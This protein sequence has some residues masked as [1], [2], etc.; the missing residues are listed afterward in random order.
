[1]ATSTYDLLDSTTLASAAS[2][3]SF[4]SIDQSYGDLVLVASVTGSSGDDMALSLNSTPDGHSFV[5]MRG[6][7]STATSESFSDADIEVGLTRNST[8]TVI[9]NIMDYSATDK[10]KSLLIRSG[11]A[12]NEVFAYAARFTSTL[13]VTSVSM[14]FKTS[15]TYTELQ[16]RELWHTN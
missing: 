8:Q 4:T 5:S 1:L 7:G 16:S 15:G 9:I 14:T 12:T 11:A 10:H 6:N 2:S 3:V 13:A